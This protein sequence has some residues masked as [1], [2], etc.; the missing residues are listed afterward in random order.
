MRK[1]LAALA[2]YDIGKSLVADET[3]LLSCSLEELDEFIEG[4][5]ARVDGWISH[6]FGNSIEEHAA[7]AKPSGKLT[8]R[9][10]EYWRDKGVEI[11]AREE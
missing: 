1:T 5:V 11:Q 4:A 10:L 6:Y 9:F 3:F 7:G 2:V 8:A